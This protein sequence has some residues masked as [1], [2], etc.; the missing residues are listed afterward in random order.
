MPRLSFAFAD[1]IKFVADASEQCFGLAQRVVVSDWFVTHLKLL[2]TDKRL[3]LHCGPNNPKR[4]F[5][6]CNQL[7]PTTM[8]LKDLGILRSQARPYAEHPTSLSA[9]CRCLSSTIRHAFRSQDFSLLWAAFQVY[10]KYNFMYAALSCILI[11]KCDIAA[12]KSV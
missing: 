7:L 1:D 12:I 2:S 10:V 8:Q 11:L 4:Q 3:F 6:I 9:N 5:V